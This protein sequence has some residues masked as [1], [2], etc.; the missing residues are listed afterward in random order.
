MSEK[1]DDIPLVNDPRAEPFGQPVIDF[2][3][4]RIAHGLP[5]FHHPR[6]EHK[7]LIYDE[8]ERRIWCDGCER[9][10]DAFDA[11]MTTV[12]YFD[13]MVLAAQSDRDRAKEAREATLVRRAAKWL[14]RVWARKMLP[15]CARCGHG[16]TPDE[17]LNCGQVS[18]EYEAARRKKETTVK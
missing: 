12:K 11:F 2:A 5:K 18:L 1:A 13:A 15:Q 4:V 7:A 6:C 16:M 10:L 17:A 3:G 14:D 9:T 8:N